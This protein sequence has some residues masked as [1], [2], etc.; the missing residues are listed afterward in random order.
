MRRVCASERL[1]LNTAGGALK[2]TRQAKKEFPQEI[3]G[4]NLYYD[5]LSHTETAVF[6]HDQLSTN[7]HLHEGAADSATAAALRPSA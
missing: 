1:F 2:K 3:Y 5:T 4:G 6:N 7:A